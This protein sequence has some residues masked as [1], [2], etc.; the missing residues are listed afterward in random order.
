MWTEVKITGGHAG[1]SVYLLDKNGLVLKNRE[2][3]RPQLVFPGVW[4]GQ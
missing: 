3:A 2:E 4:Q 1:Y